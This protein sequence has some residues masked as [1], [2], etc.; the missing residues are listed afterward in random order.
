MQISIRISLRIQMLQVDI[1]RIRWKHVISLKVQINEKIG[2]QKLSESLHDPA[3]H[4]LCL[5]AACILHFKASWEPIIAQT[6]A[7]PADFCPGSA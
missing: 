5:F 7:D 1:P 2:R 4:L 3:T 6:L